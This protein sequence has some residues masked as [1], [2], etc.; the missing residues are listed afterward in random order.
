M[1]KK[2]KKVHKK[3][4]EMRWSGCEIKNFKVKKSPKK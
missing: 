4:K 2:K 3:S 1:K